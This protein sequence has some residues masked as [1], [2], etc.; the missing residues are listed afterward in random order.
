MRTAL[1]AAG[2]M[3]LS[4]SGV[5]VAQAADT[6][7]D[8]SPVITHTGTGPTGYTVTF[9]FLAP[10][11]E[12]VQIKG[13]WYFA[14][15]SELDPDVATE[16]V[17]WVET[18]GILPA[19]WQPGDFPIAY[20][21]A[22]AAN[23]PVADLT[24]DET[25]GVWSYTTPLPSGVFSYGFFVDCGSDTGAGCTQVSDPSN[26]PWN[27]TGDV[28]V[29]NKQASSQVY[30]PADPAFGST[31][32]SWQAPA[33]DRGTLTSVTYPSPGHVT[34]LDTN[35]AVV[36]TP[37][38]YDP[39]RPRPY[40]TLYLAHGGGG[41]E[42]DWTTQGAADAILDNLIASGQ[43]QPTVV[44]MTNNNGFPSS[45][46]NEAYDQDM[47]TN[48]IPYVEDNYHVV[49]NADGRAFAGLSAGGIIAN[50]FMIKYPDTF[51]AYNEMSAGLPPAYATLTTAQAHAL[52]DKDITISSGRQ[53][54]IWAA[55]FGSNHTGGR[56]QAITFASAGLDF[57]TTMV[58]G[59]HEWY[60]WR[61]LLQDF[62]VDSDLFG[63][64][65]APAAAKPTVSLQPVSST[66]LSSGDR[67]TLVALADGSPEPTVQWQSS[68][69][70]GVT[71]SAVPGATQEVLGLRAAA[72]LDGRSYRAAFSN[73]EG[74]TYSS[75]AVVRVKRSTQASV[76]LVRAAVSHRS[77]ATVVVTVRPTDARP[78][79]S[80]TVR[81]GS[82]SKTVRMTAADRGR[83]RVQLPRLARGSYRVSA[84]YAGGTLFEPDQSTKVTLKV[85]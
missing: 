58:N 19:D 51:G 29:G 2:A 35:Y 60:V 82:R 67:F 6:P 75:A 7:A 4:V 46:F 11:A 71:W 40:P 65:P 20:P 18:Q 55:G 31:D 36:Y 72:S 74:T 13:E 84:S 63:A 10:D 69:D 3:A 81:F 78:V 15:P 77:R 5:P 14:R 70:G 17:P 26:Q 32:Y 73:T 68:S 28:V 25:T 47:I 64:A 79:G 80:I 43:V 48:L 83:V 56:K 24:Q 45:T 27:Q 22:S 62:L 52:A 50:S 85:S 42:T 38:G 23:W 39:N 57:T 41:N 53:D 37:P 61:L 49:E 8:L 54:G 34:P 16:D 1:L 44:V 12:R 33:A 21:N 30:L 59:G 66:T 76:K 9:Q